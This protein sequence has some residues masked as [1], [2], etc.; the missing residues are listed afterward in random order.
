MKAF[1]TAAALGAAL[2]S[3]GVADAASLDLA[4]RGLVQGRLLLSDGGDAFFTA[5]DPS[6]VF[7][8]TG[9]GLLETLDMVAFDLF[10]GDPALDVDGFSVDAAFDAAS[11]VALIELESGAGFVLAELLP[12][13]VGGFDFSADFD[14]GDVTLNVYKVAPIPLPAAAPLLVAA[15]AGVAALRRRA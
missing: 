11:L 4:A 15:F 2:F 6:L 13:T 5:A 3:G 7:G 8:A 9:G 10:L 1:V 12:P 14:L